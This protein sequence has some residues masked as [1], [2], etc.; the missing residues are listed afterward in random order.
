[1]DL[2]AG[3]T[4]HIATVIGITF[5]GRTPGG[6]LRTMADR[7][8][9]LWS[10]AEAV[11]PLAMRMRRGISPICAASAAILSCFCVPQGDALFLRLFLVVML[12]SR[13]WF[14]E[15]G[16]LSDP[17]FQVP[18]PERNDQISF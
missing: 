6:S 10:V 3:L 12:E 18:E 9:S 2:R 1:M 5:E 11:C 15:N 16:S 7:V 13:W 17:V 14:S 8:T 4:V